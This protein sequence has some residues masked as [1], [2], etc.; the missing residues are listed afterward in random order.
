MSATNISTLESLFIS[1]I[2]TPIPANSVCFKYLEVSLSKL[3]SLLFMYKISS[4][5][6]SFDM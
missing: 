1:A 2:E 4:V 3:P 5:W 6:K